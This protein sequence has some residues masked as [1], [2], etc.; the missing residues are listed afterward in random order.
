MCLSPSG[1]SMSALLSHPL[2]RQVGP[3]AGQHRPSWGK[4]TWNWDKCGASA[5]VLWSSMTPLPANIVL[6]LYHLYCFFAPCLQAHCE[7]Q[8][9][10]GR[11]FD[12]EVATILY[13][14]WRILCMI[15]EGR[16]ALFD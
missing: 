13:E 9:V 16:H 7:F 3:A 12:E 11:L 15:S 14:V 2:Q 4:S 8:W 5:G 10:R 6:R 1:I